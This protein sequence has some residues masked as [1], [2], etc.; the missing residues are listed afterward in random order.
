MLF[1]VILA[2]LPGGCAEEP[3]PVGA[4]LLPA[5]D[6]IHLDTTVVWGIRSY[7]QI[8]IPK[9][10]TGAR[11]LIGHVNNIECWGLL[12]FSYLPDST[13]YYPIVSAELQLRTNYHFGDSLAPFSLSI[14]QILQNWVTDSLTID[15]VKAPGFY[16]PVVSGSANYSSV[17][18][19][20][21]LTIPLDTTMIRA[22]GTLSDTLIT[23][24]GV[25]LRPTNSAVVKGF[26]SFLAAN[27]SLYPVL[28]LRFRDI[29]DNIDTLIEN[30]GQHHYV[31]TG[32]DPTW[33]SDSTHLYVMNGGAYRGFVEFDVDSLPAHGAV[34][35]ATLELT[36]DAQRSQFNMYTSDSTYAFFIANDS[37]VATYVYAVGGP[38]QNGNTRIY[39]FPIGSF[40]Q[41]W[42]RGATQHRLAIAGYTEP[43]TLDLFS[44]YGATAAPARRPKLTIIHSL[45][46]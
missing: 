39:Q 41:R 7:N 23:N 30:L 45:I 21:T 20:S 1:C 25:L 14:Y 11:I 28:L 37:T 34:H 12:R 36:L 40:V 43:N 19:T 9:A 27:A 46:Q 26:G 35:K 22:W 17:G 31:T 42:L 29:A 24:F 10:S 18:D 38:V 5:G 8:T 16:S 2:V 15:S 33:A 44:F 13:R 32:L 4:R 3:N 6:L